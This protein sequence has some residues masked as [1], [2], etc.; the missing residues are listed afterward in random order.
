MITVM[1]DQR[2]ED[3][4][5]RKTYFE[6]AFLDALREVEV[7]STQNVADFVGCSYDLAYRR[8]KEMEDDGLVR[9]EEVGN[10]FIWL[11]S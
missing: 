2:D 10:S 5:F 3:G 11:E 8:L 1:G 9:H 7:A 6:E 4:R